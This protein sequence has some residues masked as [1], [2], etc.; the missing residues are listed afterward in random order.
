M[1]AGLISGI[2]DLGRDNDVRLIRLRTALSLGSGF[3]LAIVEVEPGPI[4]KEVIR[5]IQSWSDH[6]SIGPLAIVSLDVNAALQAQLGGRSGV[7]FIG[8]EVADVSQRDWIAELNWSR[9]ALPALVS[10]PLILI[11]SHATHGA[12][13]ER[14]PDLYS[15]RR[16]T[17][18][19]EVAVRELALPLSSPG[20]PYWLQRAEHFAGLLGGVLAAVPGRPVQVDRIVLIGGPAFLGSLAD[21]YLQLGDISEASYTLDKAA[22]FEGSE[23]H[24]G[25]LEKCKLQRAS[26]AVMRHD[27]DAARALLAEVAPDTDIAMLLR[28]KLDAIDGAW[29]AAI[30]ELSRAI[31]LARA[32]LDQ[33]SMARARECLCQI[34]FARGDL[35]RGHNEI[36]DLLEVTRAHLDDWGAGLW[37]RL[38]NAV[39]DVYPDEVASML[40][41]VAVAAEY[42]AR[43]D[44]VFA[45]DCLQVKCAWL[46]QRPALVRE[47]LARARRSTIPEDATQALA[48]L[49]FCEGVAAVAAGNAPED[50]VIT[51]LTRACALLR[52]IAPRSAGAAGRVLGE[53]LRESREMCGGGRGIPACRRGRAN[54]RG[55]RAGTHSA[56]R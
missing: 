11:V 40:H 2:V 35:A 33:E 6:E 1:I 48:S 27:V 45:N 15:W 5:R 21:A 16:H 17:V 12:L 36:R 7:I 30:V 39:A 22:V 38:A 28:G 42:P 23:F 18:R 52:S 54:S 44:M 29:D 53:F 14:A 56:A 4:R 46:L 26:C 9:N 43:A 8:L 19:V 25:M 34:A 31:E 10:G 3:Q 32:P 37:L 13:F 41:A 49:S 47:A 50:D 24:V 20:D 55:L 51:P